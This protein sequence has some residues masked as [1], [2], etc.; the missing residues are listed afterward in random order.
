MLAAAE[1][2][3]IENLITARD[4]AINELNYKMDK[5]RPD[6]IVRAMRSDSKLSESVLKV[7][8][9]AVENSE[10]NDELR[11]RPELWAQLVMVS[12]SIESN[13]EISRHRIS[14]DIGN[15]V[16]VWKGVHADIE[17]RQFTTYLKENDSVR[18]AGSAKV[19]RSA[20]DRER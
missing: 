3:S 2:G 18:E 8:V 5:S 9:S 1:K 20:G 15:G 19:I 13:T 17:R 12:K 6:S 11:K 16:D 4:K 7:M 10:L 14:S